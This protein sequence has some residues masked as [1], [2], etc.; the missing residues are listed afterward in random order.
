LNPLKE[1]SPD[2]IV[3]I[4]FY[5]PIED[6]RFL[7]NE[8]SLRCEFFNML[9]IIKPNL[10]ESAIVDFKAFKS[11]HAQAICTA[12]FKDKLP[13]LETPI[14][15]LFLLDS[16]QIYPSDRALSP[17]IGLAEKMVEDNF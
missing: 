14:K 15:N 10:T 13:P 16:T 2:K 17:L 4:P 1:I 6:R 5:A 9:K 3:Y 7:M 8:E 11:P 12:G